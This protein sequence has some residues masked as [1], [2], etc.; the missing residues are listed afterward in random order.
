MNAATRSRIEKLEAAARPKGERVH[1]LSCRSKAD[2]EQQQA[3][4]IASGKAHPSDLFV[5]MVTI[6]EERPE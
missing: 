1:A 5:H 4:L 2:C 6:Y 3:G